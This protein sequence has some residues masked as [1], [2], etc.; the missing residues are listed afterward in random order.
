M[1]KLLLRDKILHIVL[2]ELCSD[3]K[4]FLLGVMLSKGLKVKI[5]EAVMASR[6]K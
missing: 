5:S 3:G 4:S 1:I 2:R 6:S